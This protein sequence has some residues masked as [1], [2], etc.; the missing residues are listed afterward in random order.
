VFSNTTNLADLAA[1][2]MDWEVGAQ[3]NSAANHKLQNDPIVIKHVQ[4]S[5]S[6]THSRCVEDNLHG[7]EKVHFRESAHV[8][9]NCNSVQGMEA[10]IEIM[11]TEKLAQVV[12]MDCSAFHIRRRQCMNNMQERAMMM[13][14]CLQDVLFAG[15]NKTDD[16]CTHN[17]GFAELEMIHTGTARGASFPSCLVQQ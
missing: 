4:V 5:A 16:I 7:L 17:P 15:I 3:T 14:S 1:P 11:R 12:R 8:T 13:D 6:Q 9:C 2:V 10:A